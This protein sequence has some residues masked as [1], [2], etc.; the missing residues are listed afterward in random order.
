MRLAPDPVRSGGCGS[1]W[2]VFLAVALTPLSAFAAVSNDLLPSIDRVR[3]ALMQWE[4]PDLIGS[5][6]AIETLDLASPRLGQ[7]DD[8]FWQ[9]YWAGVANF[10]AVL[11][12]RTVTSDEVADP[13]V[14]RLINRAGDSLNEALK[15]R[16]DHAECH[17]MLAV[18]EGIAIS[19]R[20]WTVI[21]KGPNLMR[22]RAAAAKTEPRSPRTVYLLGT[23]QLKRAKNDPGTREAMKTLEQ[24]VEL[25]RGESGRSRQPWEPDWGFDHTL[26]F[27]GEAHQALAEWTE[28]VTCYEQALEINPHLERARLGLE[29]C[30]SRTEKKSS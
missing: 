18:L 23:A 26:L 30:R 2:L 22:H 17:A 24:A 7:S 28:A 25:F 8:L 29:Q 1:V 15:I 20:P 13:D 12:A 11:C 5:A 3:A 16:S 6:D 10:N 14:S 9:H 19:E 4:L 27:L 21:Y